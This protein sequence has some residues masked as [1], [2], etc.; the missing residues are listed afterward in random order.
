MLDEWLQW[1]P[2]DNRGSKDFATFE[3]LKIALNEAGLAAAASDLQ[4]T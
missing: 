2:G 1:A 3:A 4:L